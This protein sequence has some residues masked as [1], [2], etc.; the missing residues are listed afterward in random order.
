MGL[1]HNSRVMMAIANLT[2]PQDIALTAVIA[3]Y[4]AL[5]VWS[6]TKDGEKGVRKPKSI[7]EALIKQEK[8][9]DVIA[10]ETPEEF[11]KAREKIIGGVR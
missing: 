3:D 4:L 1:R 10:Y 6:K 5:I 2:V 8:N 7:Y 9:D 11:L